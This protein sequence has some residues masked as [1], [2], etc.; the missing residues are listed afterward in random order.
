MRF[1]FSASAAD[2]LCAPKLATMNSEVERHAN[3]SHLGVHV[4][5]TA[6]IVGGTA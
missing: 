3:E 4:I 6:L 5:H 2:T 1:P